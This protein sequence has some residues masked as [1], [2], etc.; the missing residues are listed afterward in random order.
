MIL[1]QKV[2]FVL[3]FFIHHFGLLR[4]PSTTSVGFRIAAQ[5]RKTATVAVSGNQAFVDKWERTG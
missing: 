3:M 2:K 4:F 5:S 1:R